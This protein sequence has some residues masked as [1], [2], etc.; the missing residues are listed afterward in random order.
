[1]ADFVAYHVRIHAL[2]KI[3]L[4]CCCWLLLLECWLLRAIEFAASSPCGVGSSGFP[5][6]M[7]SQQPVDLVPSINQGLV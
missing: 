6:E 1:V 4:Y 7:S 5:K 3:M 2:V